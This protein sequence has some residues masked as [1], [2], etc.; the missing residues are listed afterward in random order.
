VQVRKHRTF[1][2]L[3]V[4][5]LVV[6]LLAGCQSPTGAPV[7][8][9]ATAVD[10]TPKGEFTIATDFLA[11]ESFD[12][13]VTAGSGL[14]YLRLMFDS[15]VGPDE[16]GLPSKATGIAEDWTFGGDRMSLTF[17]LRPNLV[18]QDGSAL[19]SED[20]K[21]SI[22]RARRPESRSSFAPY[23]REFIA[24]VETPDARTVVVQHKKATTLTLEYLGPTGT[25][26]MILPKKYFESV[27]EAGFQKAPM[28]SGPYRV[29]AQQLG[30][31]MTF[32]AAETHSKLRFPTKEKI[33]IRLV[34]EENSRKALLQRGEADFINVT[35]DGAFELRAA[36]FPI[37]T[38]PGE[39]QLQTLIHLQAAG[40]PIGPEFPVADVRIRRA[41][42]LAINRAEI[43]KF[44]FR[45]FATPSTAFRTYG[46]LLES[47]GA[48]HKDFA[49]E[50]NP[51][52]AR[53]L[54]AEAGYPAKFG[55]KAKIDFYAHPHGGLGEW[56]D[57]TGLLAGFWRAIGLDINY[58]TGE[59]AVWRDAYMAQQIPGAVA[60]LAID[61]S[62]SSWVEQLVAYRSFMALE[63]P[64]ALLWDQKLGDMLNAAETAG[65]KDPLDAA[66]ALRDV[67]RY[68]KDNYAP[69]FSVVNVD[70]TYVAAKKYGTGW[71]PRK[72]RQS[73]G[74]FEQMV[75]RTK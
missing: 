3:I 35:R 34:A 64:R 57:Y 46:A 8:P 32:S 5:V 42:S 54:L 68:V 30:S 59:Y 51:A 66:R 50:Y 49:D 47:V 69:G 45:D 18:F 14:F 70:A 36:G 37:V 15:L 21:F 10:T 7:P 71:T 65:L 20:V 43:A 48:S 62:S 13:S 63:L 26:N 16:L 73:L 31:S 53:Q 74:D 9:A 33:T 61:V 19:T 40:K 56:Q 28:G 27:G 60:F 23:L 38:T 24:S 72:I 29:S 44:L 67:A 75:V 11:V 12:P 58:R 22:D 1:F 6:G 41:M 4:G 2:G 25:E 52:L 55:A 39:R 17:K